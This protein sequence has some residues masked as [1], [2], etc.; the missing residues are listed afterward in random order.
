MAGDD[1]QIGNAL[2]TRWREFFEDALLENIFS[3]V[4]EISYVYFS[5]IYKYTI[6]ILVWILY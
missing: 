5:N 2:A 4:G 1:T 3:A 6:G